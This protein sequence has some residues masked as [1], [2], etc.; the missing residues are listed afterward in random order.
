MLVLELGFV[1]LGLV[2][3]IIKAWFKIYL[4]LYILGFI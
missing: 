3:G 4:G 2:L 1:R